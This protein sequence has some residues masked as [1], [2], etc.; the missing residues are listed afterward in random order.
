MQHLGHFFGMYREGK[1]NCVK[2]DRSLSLARGTYY[3]NRKVNK[4]G[5]KMMA[6]ERYMKLNKAI[7]NHCPSSRI[8]SILRRQFF[9]Q[10]QRM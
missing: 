9:H 1:T 4:K 2:S 7:T 6:H 8:V 5:N 3:P 10:R